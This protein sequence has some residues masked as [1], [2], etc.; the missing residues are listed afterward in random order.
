VEF[1]EVI[2]RR[3]MVRAFTPEPVHPAVVQRLLTAANRAPSAGFS[4]GYALLTLEGPGQLGPFWDLVASGTG[5][6]DG[7]AD[8][9]LDPLCNA[10]LVIV[11]LSCK[12]IYLDRYARPDK[13]W[14]DRDEARWPVPYWDIDTGF[15]A[16]LMLLTVVDEGLGALFFG[17]QPELF[18]GFRARYGV[19]EQYV[20]IGAV[21]V[22]HPD[23]AADQGGSSRVIS[24]RSLNDLVHRGHW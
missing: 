1:N 8:R 6:D 19:P 15:T 22:G 9:R 16:L 10:P 23:P 20:P 17:I 18:G 24:R 5:D 13:G 11:P 3:R 12:Q 14:S 2:S 21:A 4:Q 7:S